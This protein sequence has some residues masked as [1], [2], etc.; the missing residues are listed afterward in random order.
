MV[1]GLAGEQITIFALVY[2]LKNLIEKLLAFFY[3][4]F[5]EFGLRGPLLLRFDCK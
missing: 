5:Q 2:V 3:V 4:V 1:R